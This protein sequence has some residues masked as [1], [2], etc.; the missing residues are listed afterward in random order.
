MFLIGENSPVGHDPKTEL[1]ISL[2]D[3]L[4]INSLFYRKFKIHN[5]NG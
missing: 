5:W 4:L 2:P 1:G 3:K